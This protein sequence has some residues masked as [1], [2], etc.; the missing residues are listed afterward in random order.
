MRAWVVLVT[1]GC[2]KK[3]APEGPTVATFTAQPNFQKLIGIAAE[4]AAMEPPGACYELSV[5][6]RDAAQLMQLYLIPGDHNPPPTNAK[7][8]DLLTDM[9]IL[10]SSLADSSSQYVDEMRKKGNYVYSERTMESA[11]IRAAEG[12]DKL[13]ALVA[14]FKL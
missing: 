1:I 6:A 11:C 2:A 14:P 13:S 10:R 9:K 5:K 8:L 3:D 7:L 12:L 4:G